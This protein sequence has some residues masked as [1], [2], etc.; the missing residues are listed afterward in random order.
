MEESSLTVEVH[1]GEEYVCRGVTW[2]ARRPYLELVSVDLATIFVEFVQN[3][4]CYESLEVAR[5]CNGRYVVTRKGEVRR[6]PCRSRRYAQTREQCVRC[7][8]NDDLRNL[9]QYGQAT[10]IPPQLASYLSQTHW[11][12]VATFP[13]GSTKVG[14]AAHVRKT[15]RL[16]E[17]GATLA[18]YVARAADGW[19]A[20]RLE[21]L[22]AD[23][24]FLPQ[25]VTA[26]SKVL[27]MVS[28]QSFSRLHD[29]HNSIVSKVVRFLNISDLGRA[30][31]VR[32]EWRAPAQSLAAWSSLTRRRP[33]IPYTEDLD[34]GKHL[35]RLHACA[36]SVAIDGPG[37]RGSDTEFV[38][39]LS[40]LRGIRLRL[41]EADERAW[42]KGF[43]L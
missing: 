5:Y 18:T 38:V 14:I 32:E 11:L 43:L 1:F 29:I 4:T 21:L 40:V 23:S 13:N 39:D 34:R 6:D 37:P 15:S 3:M 10:R 22:L 27:G 36:G 19:I 42:R 20:R 9:H 31:V 28:P 41:V 12:Y 30:C 2:R 24:L 16:D 8:A 7:A 26:R 33:R 25:S 17:Q 35:F